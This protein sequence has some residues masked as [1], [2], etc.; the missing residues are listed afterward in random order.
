[1][2]GLEEIFYL[3]DLEERKKKGDKFGG[4]SMLGKNNWEGHC[5]INDGE[6]LACKQENGIP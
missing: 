1:M 2:E 3:C 5:K 4:K 6:D